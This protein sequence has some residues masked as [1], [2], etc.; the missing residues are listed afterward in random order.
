METWTEKEDLSEPSLANCFKEKDCFLGQCC[1]FMLF[2]FISWLCLVRVCKFLQTNNLERVFYLYVHIMPHVTVKHKWFTLSGDFYSL[3]SIVL[4][5]HTIPSVFTNFYVLTNYLMLIIWHT[6]CAGGRHLCSGFFPFLFF[7]FSLMS[8]WF[9]HTWNEICFTNE[10][11]K[12]MD[13][14]RPPLTFILL[15]AEVSKCE[16]Y[17]TSGL[18]S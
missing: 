6:I 10:Q 1:F 12:L 16:C 15:P 17:Y 9:T 4:C 18:L 14:R 8:W 3:L 7:P 11:N 5:I 13:C 2:F